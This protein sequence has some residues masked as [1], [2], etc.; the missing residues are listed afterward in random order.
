[1]KIRTP[2]TT[3]IS[4]VIGIGLA[5]MMPVGVLAAEP[6]DREGQSAQWVQWAL[7]IPTS[8]NPQLGSDDPNP[9]VDYSTAG[10][11]VVGQRGSI[12]FLAGVFLGG[13]ATRTCSVPEGKSLFFPVAN[14]ENI[15][16]PN[17]CGQVGDLSVKDLR[18]MSAAFIDG[19]TNV[20]ATLDG[21]TIRDVQR[22]QSEVFDVAL[23]DANVFDDPCMK[24]N[25]GDVPAGIFSPAVDDGYYVTLHPLKE[26]QHTLQF[27]AENPAQSFTEDVTYKLTVV[28]VSGN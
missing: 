19:V 4:A 6:D 1:M 10:K 21:K 8:V 7:S 2:T 27:H 23:P 28:P 26:G 3:R 11:C 13:T 5:L 16:T 9:T 24:A 12:W 15:N 18:A 22:L 14:S 20:S 17:V 25:L